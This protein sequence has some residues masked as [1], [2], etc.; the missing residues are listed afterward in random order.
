MVYLIISYKKIFKFLRF[1]K[2]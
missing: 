2:I 1:F